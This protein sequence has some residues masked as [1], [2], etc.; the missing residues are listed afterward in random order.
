MNSLTLT[1]TGIVTLA[2]KRQTFL[3]EG[4]VIVIWIMD[5]PK[6]GKAS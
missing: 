4:V 6:R 5:H 3:E 2:F 1:E